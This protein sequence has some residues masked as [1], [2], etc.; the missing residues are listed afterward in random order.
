[1]DEATPRP[2]TRLLSDESCHVG[3]GVP[4]SPGFALRKCV[5]FWL[6]IEAPS[7]ASVSNSVAC[8]PR[9]TQCE[10]FFVAGRQM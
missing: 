7:V 5:E 4:F 9:K 10:T 3:R 2:H 8:G 6:V 1:V